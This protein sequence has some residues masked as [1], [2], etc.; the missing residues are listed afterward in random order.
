MKGC[1]MLMDAIASDLAR[2]SDL[3]Q[4]LINLIN[5]EG[6][7]NQ[8]SYALLVLDRGIGTIEDALDLKNERT[9]LLETTLRELCKDYKSM[10]PPHGGFTEYFIWRENFEER[11]A[12]NQK[13]SAIKEEISQIFRNHI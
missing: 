2:L 9:L 10:Y 7:N 5:S 6:S 8:T 4:S 13:L 11:V 3:Y 1:R 12:A